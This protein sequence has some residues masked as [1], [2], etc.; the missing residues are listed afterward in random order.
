MDQV[1]PLHERAVGDAF[2]RWFNHGHGKNFTYDNR[3][4]EAPDLRYTDE[5]E[6]LNLEITDAYY[7]EHD[8][9][10]Q[11]KTARGRPDAPDRW[12]GMNFDEALI[13][14]ISERIAGKCSRDYGPNCVLVIS[15]RPALTT[16]DEMEQMLSDIVI[17]ER[18]PF[19]GIYL[20]GDFG[21][22]ASS[23]SESRCW[24]LR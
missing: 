16:G 14:N 3:P 23:K 6:V 2:I 20:M 18:V 5:R 1:Q 8:A 24:Q 17:P 15:V 7:D 21:S 22:T 4:R 13:V 9:V 19:A 11:W 12:A 10:M